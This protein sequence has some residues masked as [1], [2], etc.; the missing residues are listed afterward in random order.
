[1]QL[2]GTVTDFCLDDWRGKSK[3]ERDFRARRWRLTR[4]FGSPPGCTR[5]WPPA[6]RPDPY[7]SVAHVKTERDYPNDY[8]SGEKTVMKEIA[9]HFN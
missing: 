5:R 4:V 6:V 3:L 2:A 8:I 1:M 9:S 7:P